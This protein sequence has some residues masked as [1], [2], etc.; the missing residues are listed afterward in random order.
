MKNKSN[1]TKKL[2]LFY[3]KIEPKRQEESEKLRLQNDL[4]FQQNEIKRLNNKYNVEMFSSKVRGGK[5]FV[6]EQK[7]REFKK[8]LFRSKKLHKSSK[9]GRVEPR[10]LIRN[11]VENMNRTNSQKYGL[12][13]EETESKSLA[14]KKFREIFDFYRMVKVSKDSDRYEQSDILSDKKAHRKLRSPL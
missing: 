6:A 11:A 4:E 12:P 1:L 14:S 10:K 7:I 9:K 5:A 13:P 3:E 2:Q 8:L